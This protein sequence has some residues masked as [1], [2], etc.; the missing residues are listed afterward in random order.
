MVG[1][2]WQHTSGLVAMITAEHYGAVLI[3]G[4]W[5][6]IEDLKMHGWAPYVPPG[7]VVA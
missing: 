5:L 3:G 7:V 6:P 1:Q 4:Q 2:V